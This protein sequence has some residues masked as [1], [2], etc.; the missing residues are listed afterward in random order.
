MGAFCDQGCKLLQ[1]MPG[2]GRCHRLMHAVRC[3]AASFALHMHCYH[4]HSAG[5]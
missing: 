1:A 4:R 5:L 3:S 2:S